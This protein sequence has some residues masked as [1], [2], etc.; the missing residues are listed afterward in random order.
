M[1]RKRRWPVGLG[2]GTV[3]GEVG[4]GVWCAAFEVV[5]LWLDRRRVRGR[6]PGRAEQPYRMLLLRWQLCRRGL[7]SSERLLLLLLVQVRI[8]HRCGWCGKIERRCLLTSYIWHVPHRATCS[9]GNRLRLLLP[10][11]RQL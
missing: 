6:C 9:V 8:R 1:A 5:A 11:V 10:R 7:T 3:R 2:P 4:G